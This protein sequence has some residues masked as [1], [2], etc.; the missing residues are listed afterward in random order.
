VSVRVCIVTRE[1]P[2]ETA[3]GGIAGVAHMEAHALAAEGATVH[4]ISLTTGAHPSQALDGGVTVHRLPDPRPQLP[5]DMSYVEQGLWSQVAAAKYRELD[6]L[7]GFDVMETYDYYGEGL[8]VETRPET[9]RVVRLVTPSAVTQAQWAGDREPSA[10]ER[11]AAALELVALRRAD[12]ALA[13]SPLILE[14][15]RTFTGDGFPEARVLPFPLGGER[16][17]G[18]E[19][20][21]RD[22]DQLRAV[23]LGRLEPRKGADL[24]LRA[25]AAA[26]ARG[27]DV[28]LTLIGRDV[29]G[30]TGSYRRNVLIPL[31]EELSLGFA[32]VRFVS[33]LDDDAVRRR[34]LA[35][36]VAIVPSRFESWHLVTCEAIAQ[37]V[38]V[39]STDQ[40]GV[41][42]VLG[43]EEGLRALPVESDE[44]F[45]ELA[46]DALAD[47]TWL[48][49]AG[50]RGKERIPELLDSARLAR[51]RL[52]LYE[53]AFLARM[54]DG[55]GAPAQPVAAPERPTGPARLGIVVLAHN[56]VDYTRRCI[57]SLFQHTDTDFRVVV[58]DNA[59][60]DDTPEWCASVDDPRF[61][62]VRSNHNA[63]VPGGRN[64]GL[65]ALE[66][67]ELDYVVFLDNDVEVYEDWWHPFAAALEADP[68]A[69][70]A[71]EVGVK[72]LFT[73]VGR[74]ERTIAG[75]GP[76]PADMVVGFCMF[77]RADAVRLIGRFDPNMGLFWHDDDEY[78]MRARQLGY[79]VLH[80]GS[81]RLIHFEH[82]SSAS[83]EGVW[84]ELGKPTELSARNQAYLADRHR[85]MDAGQRILDEVR[86]FTAL[87]FA[88]ELLERPQLLRA[89]CSEF[90]GA[91]DATLVL[92]APGAG[93]ALI[94]R[95]QQLLVTEGLDGDD[96]ADLV[97]VNNEFDSTGEIHLA[98]DV[99]AVLSE[100]PRKTPFE[101]PPRFGADELSLLRCL[102]DR[103]APQRAIAA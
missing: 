97:L 84:E 76:L 49:T 78:C 81:K 75:R 77:M 61:G 101:A 70:I 93:E 94:G 3:F 26:R 36:D 44:Q 5:A 89:W 54:A 16:L 21:P 95:V 100:R 68:D 1:F 73:P 38:P 67:E 30:P 90:S 32:H 23:F 87:A 102:C 25:V 80:I 50:L 41:K 34:M 24:A 98:Q 53:E 42:S 13:S 35:S 63:G 10:G 82:K 72:L 11:A 9:L 14:V 69:G 74:N 91:D 12:L 71:G 2:P 66:G 48:S 20:V 4:V 103:V 62:F 79:G 60:T 83:V 99:N 18:G 33:G 88:D 47:E 37:G 56:A 15:A 6:G 57:E 28:K 22:G 19:R 96:V 92:Y 64:L 40:I 58:V 7:I 45:A 27:I 52:E 85:R 65:D 31:M 8:H 86:G 55:S 17:A 43:E 51:R 29:V 59:S 39:I 46:A